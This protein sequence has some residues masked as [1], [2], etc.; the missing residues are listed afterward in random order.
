MARNRTST[1]A[2][3]RAWEVVLWWAGLS[4]LWLLTVSPLTLPDTAAGLVAAL[5]CAMLAVACRVAL[6]GRWRFRFR[7]LAWL[8]PL[9]W[10][11]LVDT[12]RLR[13]GR[14]SEEFT[15]IGLPPQA[16]PEQGAARRAAVSMVLASSPSTVLV[17]ELPDRIL[18]HPLPHG[19]DVVR[20]AVQ[21]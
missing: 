6:G 13:P 14:V 21:R 8:V 20:R 12:L 7:W 9:G 11:V 3:M 10:E 5:A 4:G 16:A 18:V 2:A 1:G 19:H 15:E 17:D